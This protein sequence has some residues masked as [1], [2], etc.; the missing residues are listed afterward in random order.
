MLDG[1]LELAS[2]V[3][4]GTTATVRLP[5]HGG[6]TRVGRL[7]IADDDEGFRATARRMLYG[8][9]G[10]VDE[11]ADGVEALEVM[12]DRRPDVIV[13]DML[14][15]RLDGNALLQRMAE[16]ED[17]R[18]V[19]VVVVTVAPG[20]A[21]EGH[22]VLSKLDLRREELLRAVLEATGADHA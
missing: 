8:F 6:G 20:R 18:K 11:A 17:L 19:A 10:H 1:S 5:Y 13:L 22:P 12:R 9:A 14:M 3:G 4:E 21:A 7:L 2:T 15:P 16:D